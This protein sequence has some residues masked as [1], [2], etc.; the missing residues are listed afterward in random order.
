MVCPGITS[1]GSRPQTDRGRLSE[2]PLVAARSRVATVHGQPC[3]RAHFSTSRC[4]PAAARS[5]LVCIPRAVVLP[6]PPQCIQVPAR[7]GGFADALAPRAVVLPRPLQDLQVPA[8]SVD[9]GGESVP[10]AVVLPQPI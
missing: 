8:H 6:R 2:Y 1:C 7:G 5:Q 10:R 9:M 3:C 4:P